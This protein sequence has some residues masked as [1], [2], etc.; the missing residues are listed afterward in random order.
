MQ[1]DGGIG[2]RRHKRARR[3]PPRES[4]SVVFANRECQA[5]LD[6]IGCTFWQWE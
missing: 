3:T 4:F 5:E 2:K 1:E 6:R